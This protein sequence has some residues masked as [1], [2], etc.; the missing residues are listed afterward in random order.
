MDIAS[1]QHQWDLY[2]MR[3]AKEVS[4]KSKC[5]S[6]HIGAVLVRDN[7]I[8]STGYN[9]APR[10][11]KEC[12]EREIQF[13]LDLTDNKHITSIG[14]KYYS[15]CPRKEFGY[16]SGE[17]LNLCQAGH[18]ERNALIQA[19]RSGVSTKDTTLYCY[20]GQICKD[21][22]IEII[23]AGVKELIFLDGYPPYDNYAEI[24]LEESKIEI[25]KIKEDE[26]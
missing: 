19:G 20:C 18:A 14:V 4:K 8:I 1:K 9:G 12:N 5:M 26:V 23:N 15:K 3:I 10:G 21:C 2:F 17:G 11:V 16:K 24:L 22:A 6:R 13:Y 25:R 7:A